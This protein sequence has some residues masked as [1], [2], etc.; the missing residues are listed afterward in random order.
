MKK[1]FIFIFLFSNVLLASAQRQTTTVGI[2]V[3]PIFPVNF[4]N[5]G[6]ESVVQNNVKFDLTLS[7]GFS[8]GMLIRHDF[9]KLVAVEGGINYVKRK[10]E[11]N[12]T[13]RSF[14]GTSFF[15]IVGYEIP[16]SLLVYAQ[17]G[18]KTFMNASLGHSL[19]M[20]ASD[21]HSY[22][23]YFTERSFRNNLVAS[24]VLANL[25]FEYRTERSG[26]F[27]IGASYHR[28]FAFIYTTAIDYN[29]NGKNEEVSTNVLG[30]YLTMDIRYF[31]FDDPKKKNAPPSDEE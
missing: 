3:K 17:L 6:A 30:N 31:F 14:E 2:Q 28:P 11:L 24:S 4:V 12:I 22:D 23:Y 18:E 27:Y 16:T 25:G 9:S 15:R 20:F 26:N 29:A 10:Y 19:D 13:D 8:A 7:S 1:I 21:V 5:T